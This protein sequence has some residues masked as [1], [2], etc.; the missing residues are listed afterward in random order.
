MADV[1]LSV[2]HKSMGHFILT[3]CLCI[4]ASFVPPDAQHQPLISPA[5][6]AVLD[7]MMQGGGKLS[8]K[9]HFLPKMPDIGPL[10]CTLTFLNIS[11]NDFTVSLCAEGV[12]ICPLSPV[13]VHSQAFP[14]EILQLPL[15][16]CLRM[17]CNPIRSIP[18]GEHHGAC[19][20]LQSFPFS[21]QI[22][23]N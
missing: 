17:R 15:L 21:V 11:Y 20:G 8:L 16:V 7:C 10:S 3:E 1:Y 14:L 19:H 22:L 18:D 2:L 12:H 4:I 6:V 5:E 23:K 9:A 13:V